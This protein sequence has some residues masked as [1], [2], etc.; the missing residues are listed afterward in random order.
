[1]PGEE[2]VD[3]D[4]SA[5]SSPHNVSAFHRVGCLTRLELAMLIVW[6]LIIDMIG[7]MHVDERRYESENQSSRRMAAT[8]G[9]AGAIAT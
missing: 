5:R 1:M 6:Y 4:L 8:R 7:C 3:E 2:E 9:A